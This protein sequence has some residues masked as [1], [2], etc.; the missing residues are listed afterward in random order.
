MPPFARIVFEAYIFQTPD[1]KARLDKRG[2]WCCKRWPGIRKK[3]P[4]SLQTCSAYIL[5]VLV[6]GFSILPVAQVLEPSTSPFSYILLP[7]GCTWEMR[8]E[9]N[10]LTTSVTISP[11][12]IANSSY[13]DYCNC[14]FLPHPRGT[15]GK[16]PTCQFKRQKRCRFDPW[17]RKIP[18]RR[19][20]QL[21]PVFLPGEVHGQRSLVGHS[22]CSD[23]ELDMTE[24]TQ[25]ACTPPLTV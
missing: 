5:P 19:A 13:Q 11:G 20:W 16:E 18:R 3:L 24:V 9:P 12:H 23:M 8:Q 7:A 21:T 22:P 17:V 10:L 2:L 6:K 1:W 25:H 14:L 4:I 15:S